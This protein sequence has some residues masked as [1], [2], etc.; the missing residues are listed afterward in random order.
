MLY[1][2]IA[3]QPMTAETYY[4]L[5]SL[6]HNTT[7]SIKM[8]I[9]SQANETITTRLHVTAYDKDGAISTEYIQFKFSNTFY[10]GSKESIL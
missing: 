4:V 7:Y 1:F 3:A 8:P 9:L 5:T 10:S 2:E 6:T